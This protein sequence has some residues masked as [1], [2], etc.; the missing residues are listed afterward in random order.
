MANDTRGH[1]QGAA[2][3]GSLE[4][5]VIVTDWSAFV[6]WVKDGGGYDQS[7]FDVRDS[8]CL[9]LQ[10]DYL[11]YLAEMGQGVESS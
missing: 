9:A 10:E 2:A 6:E 7:Y 4:Q 8:K 3:I 11:A 5:Y 1:N